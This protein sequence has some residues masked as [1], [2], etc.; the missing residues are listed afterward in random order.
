MAVPGGS[1]S[2]KRE[3]KKCRSPKA[4]AL[5]DEQGPGGRQGGKEQVGVRVFQMGVALGVGL[6]GRY[7][8]PS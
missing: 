5:G 8:M 2:R 3:Q 7:R 1:G 6:P 4:G